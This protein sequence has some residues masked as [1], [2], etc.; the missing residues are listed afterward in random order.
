MVSRTV[1]DLERSLGVSLFDRTTR[2]VRLTPEGS[3][4]LAVAA[5][6][7]DRTENAMERFASYCRGERGSIVIAALP[8]VAAGLLPTI[9]ATYLDSHPD[10]RFHILDVTTTE[11]TQHVLTGKADFAIAEPPPLHPDLDVDVLVRD[12]VVAVFPQSHHLAERKMVTWRTLAEQPF[13][14]YE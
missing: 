2:S 12:R 4:L 8:S 10:I 14:A 3:E 7:L 1:R 9:L 11:A 13:V 6:L 5:D